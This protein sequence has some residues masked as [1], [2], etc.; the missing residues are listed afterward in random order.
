MKRSLAAYALSLAFVAAT[1]PAAHAEVTDSSASGFT[2]KVSF[3]TDASPAKT[4]EAITRVGSWWSSEHSWSGDSK[5]MTMDARAGGCFCEALT[6]G[7]S[8][9]HMRVIFAAP[10]KVLRLHGALGPLQSMAVDGIM[11]FTITKAA[12]KTHVDVRY[13]VGGYAP[14][15][16][17]MMAKPVEGV[18]AAQVARLQLLIDTGSAEPKK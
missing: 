1:V 7:G 8:V 16:L 14:G 12:G 18:L 5:N 17:A 6:S 2:V 15:G 3:D 11:D 10:G 13:Q 4:Y 9:E